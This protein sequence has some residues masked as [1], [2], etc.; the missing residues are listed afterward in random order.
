MN[1]NLEYLDNPV[2]QL[3]QFYSQAGGTNTSSMSSIFSLERVAID[4]R[5]LCWLKNLQTLY[6]GNLENNGPKV[7]KKINLVWL[8]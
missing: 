6:M 3:F 2:N 1:E 7:W 8:I 5:L 4:P